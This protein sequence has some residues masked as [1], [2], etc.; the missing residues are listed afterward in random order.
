MPIKTIKN[1]YSNLFP[2]TG[3]ILLDS[4]GL[5]KPSYPALNDFTKLKSP[6]L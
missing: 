4:R 5:L 6:K 2:Y 3:A 1:K